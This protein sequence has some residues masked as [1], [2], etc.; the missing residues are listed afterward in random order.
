[1]SGLAPIELEDEFVEV[2]LQV[3][4]PQS[5][6]DAS[7]P[8]L[9]VGADL[10][11]PWEDEVSGGVPDDMHLMLVGWDAGVA[12]PAVRLDDDVGRGG[13]FD[14][15]PDVEGAVRGDFRQSCAV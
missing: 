15:L 9:D 14:E 3:F 2:G 11:D 7:R 4:V 13:G 6:V 8:P 1:V 10:V 12:G 5:V